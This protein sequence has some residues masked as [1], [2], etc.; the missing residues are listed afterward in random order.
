M[1][2]LSADILTA[3]TNACD[4]PL[5]GS[6]CRVHGK[7][8]ARIQHLKMWILIIVAGENHFGG[9]IS[10][11]ECGNRLPLSQRRKFVLVCESGGVIGCLVR[12]PDLAS[13]ESAGDRDVDSEC[14]QQL[15][16]RIAGD[17]RFAETERRTQQASSCRTGPKAARCT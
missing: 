14:K 16:M 12:L 17:T 9:F 8:D 2:P 15:L 1:P 4:A 3:C 7:E 13:G 11:V 10:S 5:F 6:C